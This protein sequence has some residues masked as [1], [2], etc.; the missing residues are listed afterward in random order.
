MRTAEQGQAAAP[1]ERGGPPKGKGPA[2]APSL[3]RG[4][5]SPGLSRIVE[6]YQAD[7]LMVGARVLSPLRALPLGAP[8]LWSG[9]IFLLK[10]ERER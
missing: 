8:F 3:G 7:A 5:I 1:R 10:K 6:R 2:W 9:G 4:T